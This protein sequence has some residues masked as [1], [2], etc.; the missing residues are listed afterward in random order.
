MANEL[1]ELIISALE[2]VKGQNIVVL[3]V[4]D[5]TDVFDHIIIATGNS[6]RQIK[7]LADNVVE[8][9]KKAGHRPM[10]VEGTGTSEWVL[11]DFGDVIVHTM[12]PA[13]REFYNL[14]KLWGGPKL[15]EG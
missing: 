4:A 6:N 9:G 1:C 5:R 15:D 12:L 10:G 14:E 3:D 13:T 11:V 8:E 7:A 2:D